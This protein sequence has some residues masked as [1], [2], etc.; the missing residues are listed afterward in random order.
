MS[1]STTVD[2][3]TDVECKRG[4]ISQW[5]LIPHTVSKSGLLLS[6][7]RDTIKLKMLEG[8]FKQSLLG[9]SPDP[10]EFCKHFICFT[11]HKEKTE[12][13]E[14]LEKATQFVASIATSLKKLLQ[15]PQKEKDK[16][17]AKRL[18][19]V[20]I[21]KEE[22]VNAKVKV[23]VHAGITYDLYQKLLTGDPEVS[24]IRSCK[25]CTSIIHGRISLVPSITVCT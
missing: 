3:L 18:D 20:K 24:G 22:L 8:G 23:T 9:D 17:K 1:A 11:C 5:T 16:A 15:V 13:Q 12:V 6:A 25:T 21:T 10:E 7:S 14:K 19:R 2:K 4:Q